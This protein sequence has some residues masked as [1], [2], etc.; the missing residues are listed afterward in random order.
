VASIS[1]GSLPRSTDLT[2]EDYL[3]L[4]ENGGT[5]YEILDG[6]LAVTPAPL[7]RHQRVSRNLGRILDAYVHSRHL[8][9]LFYAPTDVI[10]AETS[11]VEPDL[12]FVVAARA[13]IISR[14]AI[15]GPPDLMIEILSPTTAKRDRETK[16]KLY[17]RY[18]VAHYWIL[19]PDG[20]WIELYENDGGSFRQT[21]RAEGNATLRCTLFPELEIR[22]GEVWAE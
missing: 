21:T 7:T 3:Q 17:A 1:E 2:Y 20:R 8:G 13:S 22:L 11:V 12:L 5:R 4:P 9:E 6:D 19:D 18:G 16:L 15:E 10:L 14:R